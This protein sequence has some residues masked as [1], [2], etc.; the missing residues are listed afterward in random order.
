MVNSC[1]SFVTSLRK[2][3]GISRDFSVCLFNH[4]L[5]ED[6]RDIKTN[7]SRLRVA[8]RFPEDVT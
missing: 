7:C 2:S 6:Y 4:I 1:L 5:V 8:C 3:V